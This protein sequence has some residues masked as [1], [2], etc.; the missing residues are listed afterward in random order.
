MKG[1]DKLDG[2]SRLT[3][4]SSARKTVTTSAPPDRPQDDVEWRFARTDA[5]GLR[6][7]DR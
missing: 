2:V 5:N 4:R 6:R 1:V 3:T 7:I